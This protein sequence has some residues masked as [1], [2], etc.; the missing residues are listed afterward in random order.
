MKIHAHLSFK[1]SPAVVISIYYDSVC[2]NDDSR[3][4]CM[5]IIFYGSVFSNNSSMANRLKQIQNTNTL[6]LVFWAQGQVINRSGWLICFIPANFFQLLLL[7]ISSRDNVTSSH[8]LPPSR[9]LTPYCFNLPY[10]STC[11]KKSWV[12]MHSFYL[13]PAKCWQA[14]V[15]ISLCLV[16]WTIVVEEASV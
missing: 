2:C 6:M 13:T 9:Q 12:T 11:H 7:L 1:F 15:N 8:L 5:H 4:C 10:E 16:I 14:D 3:L